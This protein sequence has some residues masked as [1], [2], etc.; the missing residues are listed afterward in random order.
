V[1]SEPD[2][3]PTY[4]QF[5]A[6]KPKWDES[7]MLGYQT[8]SAQVLSEMIVGCNEPLFRPVLTEMFS[9]MLVSSAQQNFECSKPNTSHKKK[10]FPTFSKQTSDAYFEQKKICQQWRNS[11]RPRDCS[12]PIK[13][14]I[15]IKAQNTAIIT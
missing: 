15:E 13:M 14:K 3:S 11:G 7:G 9:K 8:Q 12:H 6:K 10:N 4:T 1:I 5:Q 2:F